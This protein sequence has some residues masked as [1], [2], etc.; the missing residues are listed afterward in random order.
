MQQQPHVTAL[1]SSTTSSQPNL[2]FPKSERH[3]L[4]IRSAAS[5]THSTFRTQKPDGRFA[6][7]SLSAS[8]SAC[9]A[10]VSSKHFSGCAPK[11]NRQ[12]TICSAS[13][14]GPMNST[15][16]FR[17]TTA[18]H[19]NNALRATPCVTAPAPPSPF[20]PPRRSGRTPWATTTSGNRSVRFSPSAAVDQ[21]MGWDIR[22]SYPSS[23]KRTRRPG[24]CPAGVGATRQ[25]R[26]PD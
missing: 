11:E 15:A 8:S 21:Q 13:V 2:I 9:L 16:Y 23:T 22:P 20:R 25:P 12:K 1:Q 3:G 5:S 17:T 14:S 18:A 24:R 4:R 6:R 26:L 19:N 7:R 10:T